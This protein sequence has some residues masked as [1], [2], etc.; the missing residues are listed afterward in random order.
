MGNRFVA[1]LTFVFTGVCQRGLTCPYQHDPEKIAI[2]PPFL[3]DSCP[4]SA[5]TCHLSHDPTPSRVPFCH[6]F[7]NHGRC[8]RESCPYPHVR[9]GPRNG[10]CR[11]FAVAGYC[12]KGVECDKQHVRECP[13]FAEKGVCPNR[14]C[15]LP[16]VIRA[17]RR[18]QPA[19]STSQT[20]PQTQIQAEANSPGI[21][22]QTSATEGFA[23]ASLSTEPRVVSAESE[24]SGAAEEYISL[25]FEESDYDDDDENEDEDGSEIDQDD[26]EETETAGASYMG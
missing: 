19:I 2:C 10:V 12:D 25:T 7:A 16:H 17:N 3:S 4:N 15:K 21:D 14:V 26:E 13:D 6:H 22:Q 23:S 11:D 24:S 20:Q 8:T 5:D 1:G 18:R 9:V